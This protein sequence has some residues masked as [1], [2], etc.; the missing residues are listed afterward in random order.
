MDV[1]TAMTLK[2]RL[3]LAIIPLVVISILVMGG[4][5]L[6]IAL[7]NADAALNQSAQEKLTS[8]NTQTKAL[9]DNYFSTVE[10]QLRT[11]ASDIMVVEAAKKFIP[12]FKAY[13]S[14]RGVLSTS[15]DDALTQYYTADFANKYAD[16]NPTPLSNAS[17]LVGNL[18]GTAKTLQ[19]DFIA[20]STFPIGGK[21]GLYDLNNGTSYADV[22]SRYHGSFHQF[23]QEF[24][25]Y[26]IFIADIET[27]TIVYSVYKEL[28]FATSI[29]SGPYADTG[30]GHAFAKA[31]STTEKG[32]VS[33]S[34]LSAY[35]PSYDA[36]AGFLS[37]P[38]FDGNKPVAVLIYQIPLDRL[39]AVLTHN[40][41][42]KNRGFGD[43]GE[44]YIINPNGTLL[45]ESRFFVE[46]QR[47]Y[48]DVIS[49][50]MPTVAT[51]VK[52]RGTSV[53]IQPVNSSS[54]KQALAG[55]TGFQTIEDYRG[56]EVFSMYSPIEVGEYTYGLMAEIDT[57]EA[58]ASV[59]TIRN[60]LITNTIIEFVIIVGV[61]IAIGF[62][63]ANKL[64]APLNEVGDMCEELS[65]G[66]ADLT[67]RLKPSGIPEIDRIVQPFNTFIGQIRDIVANVKQ[68]AESLASASEELSAITDQSETTTVQQRDMTDQVATALEE[69]SASITEVAQSTQDTQQFSSGAHTSL[70]E[71]MERAD[72]AADNIKLLVQLIR[73]SSRIITS[74]QGE[75]NQITSVLNVITSIADQT[76]LLALNAAIEAA[77]AGDA[78]RGFSVVADEVRAL[79]NRSQENTVEISKIVEKMN[80]SS[81]K[82]VKAMEQ[83][84]A[85]AD[86]GIHLVDLV[87]VAMDELSSTLD[88]VQNM[89]TTVA[90]ATEQQDVTSSS[91]SSNVGQI[92][93][94]AHDVEVGARQTSEAA[95]DLTRI[96]HRASELVGRFKV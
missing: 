55:K 83:A 8:Q 25:Y 46:D 32:A 70:K 61:A 4:M 39:N 78:G 3:L 75:V 47:G 67:I 89:T 23:L 14:E 69:L 79:A 10:S 92:N 84:A 24:G 80:D 64:V 7:D 95:T 56:I 38:I 81:E 58:L 90:A 35:L 30:I 43:S 51:T 48:L 5:S 20:S 42:W 6:K 74:L 59:A 40:E 87:T 19:Y 45:T 50:T 2:L 26:D 27:G 28:D 68:D 93:E 22:H 16:L 11:K 76:N 71:N 21:D 12:A 15:Q 62:F 54:A 65:S 9:V 94:M 53:G 17:S 77:R 86:G 73:D 34:E 60:E 49:T 41:E 72:M 66:D 13:T 37:T 44:T 33:F 96:A 36:L 82:S 29:T 52:A 63:L 85:A 31:K 18:D 57:S 1:R 88:S 91:V